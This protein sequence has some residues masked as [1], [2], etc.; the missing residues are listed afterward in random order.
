MTEFGPG[1]YVTVFRSRLRGDDPPGYAEAAERMDE[2]ARTMPGFLEIKTFVA[3]DG[4]RVSITTF[5]DRAS[6]EAWRDHPE[7]RATQ[8]RGQDSF[9]A[10]YSLQ[11][12]ETVKARRFSAGG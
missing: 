1:Q 11:V 4:E 10:E 3:E 8:R 2:L 6:H 5:A 7:H 9:Y 12:A